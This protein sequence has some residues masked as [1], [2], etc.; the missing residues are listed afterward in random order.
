MQNRLLNMLN[1]LTFIPQNSRGVNLFSYSFVFSD[2][3]L[4]LC[5]YADFCRI[6]EVNRL[7]IKVI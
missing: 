3:F 1:I 7:W 2:S 5:L 4:Y 6:F